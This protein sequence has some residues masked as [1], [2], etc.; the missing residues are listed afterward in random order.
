MTKITLLLA[1]LLMSPMA[2]A[3]W[4]YFN[5]ANGTADEYY[6]SAITPQ[7]KATTVKTFSAFSVPHRVPFYD[8][9]IKGKVVS[10]VKFSSEQSS[11]EFDCKDKTVQL[12]SRV[13]YADTAGKFPIISYKSNDK[14]IEDDNSDFSKQFQKKPIYSDQDRNVR[15][16]QLACP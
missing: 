1:A 3:A 2:G 11:F 8:P 5:S 16:M 14:V 7:G 15:L 13:F 4:V 12:K 6:D 9:K 10:L